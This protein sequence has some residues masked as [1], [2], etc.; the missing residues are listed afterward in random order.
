[1]NKHSVLLSLGGNQKDTKI[2]FEKSLI[3]IE[4]SIGEVIKKSSL[5][6]SEPWGFDESVPLFYNQVIEV[7][8]TCNPEELLKKTQEI[9]TKLGRLLKTKT[10][11]ESRIID[12]DILFYEQ[13]VI[14]TK[15]LVIPHYLIHKRRFILLPLLEIHPNFIH[16][17][18]QKTINKLL[19]QCEDTLEVIKI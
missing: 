2:I 7:L 6:T 8:T 1:M 16:P 15:S 19:L 5:Y 3:E 14:N 9:E 18:F 10:T 13:V 4:Q 11:Y 17:V 12:I